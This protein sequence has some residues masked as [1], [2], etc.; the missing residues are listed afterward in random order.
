[1]VSRLYRGVGGCK[2]AFSLQVERN[3][4]SKLNN[5][6][7]KVTHTAAQVSQARVIQQYGGCRC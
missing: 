3:G 7:P 6:V 1:M 4:Q 5:M 2:A